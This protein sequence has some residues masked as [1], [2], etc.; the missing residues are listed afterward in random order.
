MIILISNEKN[1]TMTESKTKQVE[2]GI[3]TENLS[4]PTPHPPEEH[5]KWGVRAYLGDWWEFQYQH[6]YFLWYLFNI[7][8][9]LMIP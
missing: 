9:K 3:N 6:M 2:D 5:R 1:D 7:A 8:R 4:Q